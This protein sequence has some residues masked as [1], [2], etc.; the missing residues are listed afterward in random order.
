MLDKLPT[1]QSLRRTLADLCRAAEDLDPILRSFKNDQQLRVGVRDILGKGDVQATTG[2]LSDIAEA[3]LEQIMARA[4]RKLAG[5]FGEPTVGQSERA[6]QKAEL[7]IVAMGKFGGREMNYHSD[8]DIVLLYEA[9]GNTTA[10]DQSHPNQSTT[11]Q[12]FYSELGQ[13]IIKTTSRL[14]AHGRLYEVD[15]RLR[16]T[17][18]SG[19]LAISLAEFGRYFAEGDGRL[20]ERQAL[21]KA[22]VVVGSKRM[23]QVAITAV[24]RAAFEHRWHPHDA[25]EIRRMRRRLE[26]TTSAGDLKRGPGGIVDIEF[27]VQMLQLK[28]GR[29]TKKVRTP[30]TIDAL[31]ALHRAGHLTSDD[32][33]FFTE[34]YRFLRTLEGRLRLLNSTA[35]DRLPDE[36]TELAKLAHLLRSPS[37]EALL[38][39]FDR[40]TRQ[41]RQRFDRI[42]DAE[43]S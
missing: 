27:L 19:A 5:K 32:F 15:A 7:A 37:S 38:A 30:N 4:Y 26:K 8:L 25:D 9:D 10:T 39:D 23:A 21:C 2:T 22:R 28:H 41:T 40:Y 12:H 3:C 13:R 17:G 43:S 35:R 33:E 6:G 42:F 16:P 11:N 31:A 20:W 24:G 14:S 1:Q 18:R 29:H 36:P 34:S